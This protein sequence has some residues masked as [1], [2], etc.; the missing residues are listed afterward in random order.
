MMNELRPQHNIQHLLNT[1]PLLQKVREC[2]LHKRLNL[3]TER[4]Y[5]HHIVEYIRYCKTRNTCEFVHPAQ[6]G[7]ADIRAYL[8]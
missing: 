5:L 3:S 1:S 8:L 6:L 4:N 2:M 7:A